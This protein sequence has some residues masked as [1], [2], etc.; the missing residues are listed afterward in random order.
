MQLCPVDKGILSRFMGRGLCTQTICCCRSSSHARKKQ[1]W[2]GY[3]PYGLHIGPLFT[4]LV[5]QIIMPKSL[6]LK[7]LLATPATVDYCEEQQM[8]RYLKSSA[9]YENMHFCVATGTPLPYSDWLRMLMHV[10]GTMHVG[11]LARIFDEEVRPHLTLYA[12]TSALAVLA[13]AWLI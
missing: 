7:A 6:K 2:S 8:W 12:S 10:P 5:V 9:F 11:E 13:F 4:S 1:N 3:T